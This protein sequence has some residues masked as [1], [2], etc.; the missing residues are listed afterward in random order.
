MYTQMTEQFQKSFKPFN[1]L[2]ALNVKTMETLAANQA[3]FLKSSYQDGVAFTKSL[4]ET[5]DPVA[6]FAAQRA[7]GA[8]LQS[9]FVEAGKETYA[10]LA[11]AREQSVE[12]VKA[13]FTTTDEAVDTTEEQATEAKTTKKAAKKA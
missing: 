6:F 9:K 2:M 1:D 11:D 3:E 12:V 13:A 4:T 8:G 7:Y 10:V 5:R